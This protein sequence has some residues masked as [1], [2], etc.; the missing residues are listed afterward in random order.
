MRVDGGDDEGGDGVGDEEDGY[1][2]RPFF[3]KPSSCHWTRPKPRSSWG[4]I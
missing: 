3:Q 2:D 4:Q 1:G